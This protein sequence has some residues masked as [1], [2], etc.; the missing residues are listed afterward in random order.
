MLCTN[1]KGLVFSFPF[2]SND[3]KDG[4]CIDREGLKIMCLSY[5]MLCNDICYHVCCTSKYQYFTV[6]YATPLQMP[7][8]N[9][10]VAE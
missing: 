3:K 4:L 5:L 10:A 8:N 1:A 7:L 2:H 9:I 6:L